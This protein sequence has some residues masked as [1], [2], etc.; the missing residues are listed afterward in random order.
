MN[1]NPNTLR[2]NNNNER[3]AERTNMNLGAAALDASEKTANQQQNLL[4]KVGEWLEL[5]KIISFYDDNADII[6]KSK[7]HREGFETHCLLVVSNIMEKYESGDVS[8]DAVIAAFLHDIAKPRTA[9]F[10]KRGDACFYGHEEV[11]KEEV[12]DFLNPDYPDFDIVMDLIHGHMLPHGIGENTPEPFRQQ[13]KE[14]LESLLE[15]HDEQFGKD[16]LALADCD[17]RASVKSD[18]DLQE[19]EKRADLI[20]ANLIKTM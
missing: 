13:N 14:K 16:L 8:E 18:D 15:K 11:K 5:K 4:E 9:A 10:N 1:N 20:K 12:E 2:T 3:L 6:H 7:Y 19:A 17:A